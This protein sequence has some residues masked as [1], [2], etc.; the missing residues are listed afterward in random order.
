MLYYCLTGRIYVKAFV[1]ETVTK[2]RGGEP[3][4]D[5]ILYW[6]PELIS[7]MILVTLPPIIDSLIVSNSQSLATY[8]ALAMA[9]NFLYTLT[10]FAEAIP[11][12]AVA[13]IGR[14]NGAQD[15][16]QCGESL[17]STF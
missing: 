8:G 4:K 14:Y 9:A 6:L 15:Y 16:E 10:K 13:L 11:V 7:A 17:G 3:V 1:K 2:M 12:A 5:I